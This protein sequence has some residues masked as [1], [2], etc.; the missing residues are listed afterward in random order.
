MSCVWFVSHTIVSGQAL[1]AKFAYLLA[2]EVAEYSAKKDMGARLRCPKK[3]YRGTDQLPWSSSNLNDQSR[4][5]LPIHSSPI[6][7]ISYRCQ[8]VSFGSKSQKQIPQLKRPMGIEGLG[9][10]ARA[11]KG[12]CRELTGKLSF[13]LK[14][15]RQGFI[16]ILHGPQPCLEERHSKAAERRIPQLL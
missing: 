7:K 2:V 16:L 10:G 13:M 6:F 14:P 1:K 12:F 3:C 5:S 8:S 11:L 9:V 15:S 4:H